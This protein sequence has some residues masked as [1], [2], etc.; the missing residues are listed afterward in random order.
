[1]NEIVRNAVVAHRARN[2]NSTMSDALSF[3]KRA[4][5]TE[6][7]ERENGGIDYTSTLFPKSKAAV[8]RRKIEAYVSKQFDVAKCKFSLCEDD[9]NDDTW[10]WI[11]EFPFSAMKYAAAETA[12]NGTAP[13]YKK[14]LDSLLDADIDAAKCADSCISV[15]SLLKSVS[16]EARPLTGS[17]DKEIAEERLAVE[18][19]AKTCFKNLATFE[20]SICA[21]QRSIKKAADKCS[22]LA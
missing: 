17:F 21:L 13:L 4:P 22:N 15:A 12:T 14:M 8:V 16:R 20:A 18:A 1:M 6:V 7:A 19:C 10:F 5:F 9:S 3:V 11:A 2:A